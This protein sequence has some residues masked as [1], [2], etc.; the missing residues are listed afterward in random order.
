M[1]TAVHLNFVI[2]GETGSDFNCFDNISFLDGLYY[3]FF[4]LPSSR[5]CTRSVSF[6]CSFIHSFIHLIV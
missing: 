5:D 3:I 2:L 6:T 1:T 4:A